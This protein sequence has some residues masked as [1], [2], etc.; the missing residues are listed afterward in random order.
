MFGSQLE[1]L[2]RKSIWFRPFYVSNFITK[3]LALPQQFES[4]SV[5]KKNLNI[6]QASI[7]VR[8]RSS[9]AGFLPPTEIRFHSLFYF[10]PSLTHRLITAVLWHNS[11]LLFLQQKTWSCESKTRRWHDDEAVAIRYKVSVLLG[12]FDVHFQWIIILSCFFF[13]KKTGKNGF[14]L[15]TFNNVVWSRSSVIFTWY[16]VLCNF[17]FN[18]NLTMSALIHPLSLKSYK[19]WLHQRSQAKQFA[20]E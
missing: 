3:S 10:S 15:L 4:R 2:N 11:C 5:Q 6:F 17:V 8:N 18:F 9:P 19:L 14:T 20:G 7:Q 13:V 16:F 12:N 1:N